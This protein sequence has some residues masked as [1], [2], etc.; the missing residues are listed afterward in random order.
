[1]DMILRSKCDICGEQGERHFAGYFPGYQMPPPEWTSHYLPEK[2]MTVQ[3]LIICP[4]HSYR[5]VIENVGQDPPRILIEK[6]PGA[7][8]Q[9][10]Q[11]PIG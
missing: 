10:F 4:K 7:A 3:Q 8:P 5:L 11:W 9:P 1:M 6:E 2:W